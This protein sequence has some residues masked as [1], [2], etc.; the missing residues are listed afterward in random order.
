MTPVELN[1]L[2]REY[3]DALRRL[4]E[5]NGYC[6]GLGNLIAASM[7][8]EPREAQRPGDLDEAYRDGLEHAR[9]VRP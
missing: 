4:A 7:D 6:D 9:K 3:L 8:D 2:V 1:K 5:L